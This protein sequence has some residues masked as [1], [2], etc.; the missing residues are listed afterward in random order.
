M[1]HGNM[2]AYRLINSLALLTGIILLLNGCASEPSEFE[3]Q[4]KWLE[5]N[6]PTPKSEKSPQKQKKSP[7]PLQRAPTLSV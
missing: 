7:K 5:K 6:Y 4:Q 2:T 3:L 1:Y